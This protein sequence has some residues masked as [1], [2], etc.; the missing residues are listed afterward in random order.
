M[1]TSSWPHWL[2]EWK[3]GVKASLLQPGLFFI[4]VNIDKPSVSFAIEQKGPLKKTSLWTH[5]EQCAF[6]AHTPNNKCVCALRIPLQLNLPCLLIHQ[7]HRHQGHSLHSHHMPVES[8]LSS[9][10]TG[11]IG[12]ALGLEGTPFYC[13]IEVKMHYPSF[14]H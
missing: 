13:T 5:S 6:A 3:R 9:S 8:L 10:L 11:G 1:K 7:R 12:K 2:T 14:V 4:K